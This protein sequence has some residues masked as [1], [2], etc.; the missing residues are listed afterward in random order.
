MCPIL[1]DIG[2]PPN[3]EQ[4]GEAP[5]AI[6]IN[7]NNKKCEQIRK[8]NQERQRKRT[9][10]KYL[11]GNINTNISVY[12]VNINGLNTSIKRKRLAE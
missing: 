8:E 2:S 11:N 9:E 3:N 10:N 1:L 5:G 6:G 12:T 4:P 7:N